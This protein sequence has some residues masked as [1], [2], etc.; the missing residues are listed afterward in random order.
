MTHCRHKRTKIQGIFGSTFYGRGVQL[1]TYIQMIE[2][3]RAREGDREREKLLRPLCTFFSELL[4][5]NVKQIS[6]NSMNGFL[7]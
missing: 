3:E 6:V 1:F 5:I 2:R 4:S 7:R